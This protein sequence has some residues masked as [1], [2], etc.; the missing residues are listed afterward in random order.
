MRD[1][2]KTLL[3]AAGAENVYTEDPKLV[4]WPTVFDML[5]QQN[6]QFIQ[7][8]VIRRVG[9]VPLT[10]ETSQYVP[11]G[12]A[13]YWNHTFNVMLFF[14]YV[15][16]SSEDQMHALIDQVLTYMQGKRTLG[17]TAFGVMAPL[18]LTGIR[19]EQLGGIGGYEATFTLV[20]QQHES[21]V[22]ME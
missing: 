21:G 3:E 6:K 2:I 1:S 10:S 4:D 16:G 7:A 17:N 19:P 12:C 9:S 22:V 11:I 5:V 15:E 13:I 18:T 8:W 20:A 14:G